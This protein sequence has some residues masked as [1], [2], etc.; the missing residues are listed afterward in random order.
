MF[1]YNPSLS[2]FS[3]QLIFFSEKPFYGSYSLLDS[4]INTVI[5]NMFAYH[6]KVYHNIC[7][8]IFAGMALKLENVG[9]TFS[10]FNPSPS[11]PSVDTDDRKYCHC[12]NIG[13]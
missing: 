5:C 11:L 13:P 9:P 6:G 4:H 10:S 3:L 12:L 7:L 2:R 1:N 8:V